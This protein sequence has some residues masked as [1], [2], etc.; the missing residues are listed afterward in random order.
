MTGTINPALFG[1][2]DA[3]SAGVPAGTVLTAYTGPMTITTDGTVIDGKIISGQLAVNAANVTIKNCVIKD[4]GFWGVDASYDRAIGNITIQNCDF[5][6]A[7]GADTDSAIVGSGN[8]I[9]NDISNGENGIRLQDGASIVRDNYIHDLNDVNGDPHLDGIAA[10]G[11]QNHVLI[12]HNTVSGWDTSD[13]FIKNDFGPIND[14]VVRNNLLISDPKHGD[15]A[16]DIYVYGPNT[17]NITIT[18][19]YMEKPIWEYI[20]ILN[21]NPTISGNVQWDNNTQPT[22]YPNQTPD[23]TPPAA[24]S[25]LS[26]SD[27]T[28]VLGDHIT[29]DHTL[30]LG[31][32]AEANS[33]VK[34]FDGILLL[35]QI[36]ANASGSWSFL[37]GTL[38]EMLHNFAATATD[39]AGNVSAKSASFGVTVEAAPPPP[40]PDDEFITIIGTSKNNHLTGTSEVDHI[41]GKGG[42]DVLTGLGSADQLTGGTGNDRFDFNALNDSAPG[43]ADTIMDFVHASDHIDLRTIDANTSLANNQAFVFGGQNDVAISHGVTWHE[44]NGETVVTANVTGGTHVDFE[45]HLAGT[46]LHLAAT[47]FLL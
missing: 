13:I 42:D 31:G 5:R 33:L 32:T 41:F 26:F 34:V 4:Y 44:A 15:V 8:F 38:S 21:A 3:A 7:D 40:P 14:I 30:L 17:T 39:A 16:S 1:M 24:P 36:T 45:L 10:Q 6:A 46:N 47:D 20:A 27:D 18:G 23:T 19:N 29:S 35:G 25:V 28:G 12:E 37:T 11:G 2:P 9:G 22:P 43:A